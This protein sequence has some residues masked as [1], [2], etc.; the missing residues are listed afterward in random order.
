MEI[1]L[2]GKGVFLFQ[3]GGQKLTIGKDSAT[4]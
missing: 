4:I 3:T 1:I 2:S